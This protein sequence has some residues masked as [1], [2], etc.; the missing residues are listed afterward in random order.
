MSR[1]TD[2]FSIAD[3]AARLL[4]ARG[5][6]IEA[7][8]ITPDE[9]RVKFYDRDRY[10]FVKVRRGDWRDADDLWWDHRGDLD[11]VPVAFVTEDNRD[12]YTCFL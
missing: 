10:V 4:Y 5:G 9:V 2:T 12:L 3:H 6:L 11:P 8:P 1:S 7:C